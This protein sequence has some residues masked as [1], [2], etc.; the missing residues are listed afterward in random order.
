M[1][2]DENEG[3]GKLEEG[4][5]TAGVKRGASFLKPSNARAWGADE[6]GRW[7]LAVGMPPEYGPMFRAH[8]VDGAAL[9]QLD[10]G[11]LAAVGVASVGHRARLV[12]A[13]DELR[14]S[15]GME[16]RRA[17]VKIAIE[18][19]IAA[20]KSTFLSILG[21]SVDFVVVPEP[22]SKWQNIVSEE[23]AVTGSQVAG[24]N[25]LQMFYDDPKRWAYT[26]QSYAFLSRMRAQ[27]QPVSFFDRPDGPQASPA[28]KRRRGAA[29]AAGPLVQFFERS[30][31]SDR[32]CFALNCAEAGTFSEVE[33]NTYTDSH[34]W[35]TGTLGGCA[36]QGMIYLRTKPETCFERLQ[37][38][39]RSEESGV[40]LEYLQSIHEKH[41][42]WLMDEEHDDPVANSVKDMPKLVIQ[43]DAEFERDEARCEHML[44]EVRKFAASL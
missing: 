24:G 13:I 23:D 8:D 44:A 16:K 33:W 14:A 9:L 10:K 1:S 4:P 25:L 11:D 41:E 27:S 2:N 29:A 28:R 6:V 37:R 21:K 20:G 18:G 19:N 22:V 40:S 38:R 43:A 32:Y 30:V 36:I 42:A 5:P 15:N 17:A 35:L 3:R 12:G 31:F 39:A 34:T 7:L 26:F